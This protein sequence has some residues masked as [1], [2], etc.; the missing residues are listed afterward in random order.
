MGLGIKGYSN[1]VK[2]EDGSIEIS[3][4]GSFKQE[5][6]KELEG[7]TLECEECYKFRAGS[8][9]G[10]NRF[11]DNLCKSAN[12]ITAKELWG[13]EDE[14]LKFYWLINFSDCDGYIGTSYCEILYNEFVKYEDEILSKLDGRD[15]NT[16]KDFKECF[17][18]G[19][20]KGF[21]LFM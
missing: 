16:Y 15:A 19:R 4:C 13:K 8:Y 9:G 1:I 5:N 6:L 21:V 17:N 7:L 3:S 12:G 2:D 18:L 20:Q 11:R 10:Y 14:S